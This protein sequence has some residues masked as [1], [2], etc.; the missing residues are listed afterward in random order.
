MATPMAPRFLPR[1]RLLGL[2]AEGMGHDLVLVC[3][4]PGFGKT[5]LL[6]DWARRSQQ[7][8]AWL[9]LDDGDNDPTRF[10]RYAAAALDRAR[11][12]IGGQVAALLDGPQPSPEAVVTALLNALV[13]QADRL[14]LVLDDYHVIEARP[15]HHSLGFLLD[16]LPAQLQMVVAS[17][18]D[19]PLPLPRLRARG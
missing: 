18:T 1:F 8:I 7:P 16:R 11:P 5:S 19:P 2:L 13:T 14:T 17:R 10:W 15:I 4:P 9:S 6:G 3:T 12:G